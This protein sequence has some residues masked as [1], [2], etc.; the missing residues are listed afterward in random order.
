MGMA[1]TGGE[2]VAESQDIDVDG[3]P[4]L[5]CTVWRVNKKPGGMR[6]HPQG[7]PELME[8]LTQA[9]AGALVAIAWPEQLRQLGVWTR[10][11]RRGRTGAHDSYQCGTA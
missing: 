6:R 5:S 3:V 11:S 9:A 8:R 10:G 4:G 1:G 7:L 2:Q